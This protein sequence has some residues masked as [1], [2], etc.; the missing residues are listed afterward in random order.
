MSRV[1]LLE[2]EA[3]FIEIEFP[4]E[5]TA[6]RAGRLVSF[7]AHTGATTRQLRANGFV[8]TVRGKLEAAG[9][10]WT[11]SESSL[12]EDDMWPEWPEDS[13]DESEEPDDDVPDE[14]DVS[15]TP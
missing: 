1:D 12:T 10:P 15:P 6:Q 4:D 5:E 3:D 2:T 13:D 14:D 7:A 8:E 11:E 9:I